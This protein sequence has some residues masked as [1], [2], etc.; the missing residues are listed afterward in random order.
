M[1]DYREYEITEKQRKVWACELELMKW[2][3]QFCRKY[4]L[5]YYATSGT[6]LGAV[7]HGGFIPWDDDIDLV[8]FR[9]DYEKMK[10]LITDELPEYYFLQT[11]F[12]DEL[13]MDMAKLRDSRTTAYD[14]AS[15][16]GVHHGIFIDIFVYD[17][18]YEGEQE[19]I[20]K[21]QEELWQVIADP[22]TVIHQ[23]IERKPFALPEDIIIDFVVSP[24]RDR[25]AQFD[26]FCLN[27]FGH[28]S[29]VTFLTSGGGAKSEVR[30]RKWYE[31]IVY[32][33]FEDMMLPVPGE[34]HKVLSSIYGQYMNPVM[35]TQCH[36]GTIFEP[37]IPY[38]QFVAYIQQG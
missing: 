9:D 11:A 5:T 8:M 17:D 4:G 38:T 7:R 35:G 22:V 30:E 24:V 6:L 12:T 31:R 33:P 13:I 32:L 10:V 20:A 36:I 34:Y 2:F 29:K 3:D 23:L 26:D 18:W 15:G 14:P 1:E 37:E 19:S 27:H 16:P 28:T 25:I 21:M